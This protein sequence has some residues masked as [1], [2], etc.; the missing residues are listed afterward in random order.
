[1]T[2]STMKGVWISK[3]SSTHSGREFK[4]FPVPEVKAQEALIKSLSLH[5]LETMSTDL[6]DVVLQM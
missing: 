6:P 3:P 1:M 2:A 4:D 5:C